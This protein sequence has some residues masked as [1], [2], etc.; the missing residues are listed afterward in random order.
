[1][2]A[3]ALMHDFVKGSGSDWRLAIGR[4]KLRIPPILIL[5]VWLLRVCC[6]VDLTCFLS[7]SS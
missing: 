2:C 1:V 7:F 5:G 6:F 4:A 3:A